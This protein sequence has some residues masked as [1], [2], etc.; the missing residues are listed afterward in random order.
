LVRYYPNNDA[1]TYAPTVTLTDSVI[2]N[3]E[4]SGNSTQ[5]GV[6]ARFIGIMT[7]VTIHDVQSA[8]IFTIDWNGGTQ[9]NISYPSTNVGPDPEYHSNGVYLGP[10]TLGQSAG[11]IRN[12]TFHD[13]DAGANMAYPNPGGG[14]T[15]YVYNNLFYGV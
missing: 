7:R 3:S 15:V 2:E 8:V 11:Y 12:S 13:V 9:Y 4:N 1:S 6:A 10:G 5:T 14:R